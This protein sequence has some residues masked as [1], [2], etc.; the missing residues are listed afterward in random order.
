MSAEHTAGKWVPYDLDTEH[1][2][3][4]SEQG[5][6]CYWDNPIV[7][8]LHEDVTPEDSVTLGKWYKKFDNATANAHLI[9]AAPDLLASVEE[10]LGA[11][12]LVPGSVIYADKLGRAREAIQKANGLCVS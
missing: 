2:Y 9:S 8:N 3:V 5:K 12:E 4:I 6:R 10:L 7:C 11:L 1:P